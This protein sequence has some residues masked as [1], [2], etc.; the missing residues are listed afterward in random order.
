M[1]ASFF[2]P[3]ISIPKARPRV[4]RGKKSPFP[5]AYTPKSTVRWERTVATEYKRQ[6]RG[7]F[8][9]KDIPVKLDVEIVMPG[10]GSRATIRGDWENHAKSLCDALN[11]T[12]WHDD[13]QIVEAHVI[14]RRAR[15]GEPAGVHVQIEAI[16]EAQSVLFESSKEKVMPWEK[17]A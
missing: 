6:C 9:A 14:K 17:T 11:L 1:K 4:V 15:K 10:S 16:A 7:I 5:I 2:I 8:F 3:G 12:A 13:A